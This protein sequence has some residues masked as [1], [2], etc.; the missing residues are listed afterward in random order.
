MG[1][2]VKVVEKGW[3][4]SVFAGMLLSSLFVEWMGFSAF[5]GVTYLFGYLI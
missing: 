5:M 1:K 4:E 2:T 3:K